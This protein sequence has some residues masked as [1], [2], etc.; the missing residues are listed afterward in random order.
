MLRKRKSIKLTAVFT[1]HDLSLVSLNADSFIKA[2]I[3]YTK[4]SQKARVFFNNLKPDGV[5]FEAAE[6]LGIKTVI[7]SGLPGIYTPRT[8]GEILYKCIKQMLIER[9]FE[10]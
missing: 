9:G 10:L 4:I 7:A 1:V 3:L 8:A 2:F 5:D 6:D